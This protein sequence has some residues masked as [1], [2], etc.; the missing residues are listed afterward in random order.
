[1][2]ISLG[3]LTHS[4]VEKT[5]ES[6]HVR[7]TTIRAGIFVTVLANMNV[8]VRI[9]RAMCPAAIWKKSHADKYADA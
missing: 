9:G 2:D 3:Y 6:I 7:Q 8:A 4:R 5:A 1:M